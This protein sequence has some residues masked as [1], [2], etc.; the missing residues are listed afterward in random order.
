M[1]R[2]PKRGRSPGR[3]LDGARVHIATS[4]GQDAFATA[5]QRAAAMT[6]DEVV[7]YTLDQLAQIAGE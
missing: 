2:S 3:H 1:H 7:A 5:R 6:Y 4:L